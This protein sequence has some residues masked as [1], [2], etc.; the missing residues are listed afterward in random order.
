MTHDSTFI[1]GMQYH[2][3]CFSNC[4]SKAHCISGELLVKLLEAAKRVAQRDA[5]TDGLVNMMGQGNN[6]CIS[7]LN[8]YE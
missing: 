4:D 3:D 7:L 6:F 2:A 1:L 8:G 5:M